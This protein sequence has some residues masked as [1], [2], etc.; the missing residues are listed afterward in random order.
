[1][2]LYHV[3]A[4]DWEAL[5]VSKVVNPGQIFQQDE[6][7]SVLESLVILILCLCLFGL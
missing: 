4:V 3:L 2:P 1:M 5:K 6:A 7:P